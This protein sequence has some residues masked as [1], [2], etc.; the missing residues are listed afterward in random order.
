ML[1]FFAKRLNELHEVKR[2]E[3]GFTLIELLVV[4][5]IIGI[6]AA[7]AIPVFLNQRTSAQ[8]ASAESDLRNAAAAA[9][10]CFADNSGSYTEPVANACTIANLQANYD[11]NTSPGVTLGAGTPDT[12]DVWTAT[13]SHNNSSTVTYTYSSD[14]GSVT[15]VP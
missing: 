1:H 8:N 14:N 10:A 9:T 2:E 12:A 7:I 6:L 15:E 5:I 4:V 11:V 13:A 3:R